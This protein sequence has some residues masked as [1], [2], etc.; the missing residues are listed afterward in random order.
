M[1]EPGRDDVQRSAAEPTATRDDDESI[2]W[3]LAAQPGRLNTDPR[4]T[5]FETLLR[6]F[7]RGHLLDL[8]CGHG[9]FSALAEGLGWSVT[10]VDVRTERRPEGHPGI[11]W[12]ES[13]VR[14][15]EVGDEPDVIAV[16][17]LLYHLE[18]EAQRDL[19]KRCAHR[20]T[21]ID[22]HHALT[23]VLREGGYEGR[24]F[25]EDVT[26]PTASWGNTASFWPTEDSFV[27]M[28]FDAGYGTVLRSVPAYLPD[29]TFWLCLPPDVDPERHASW[30]SRALEVIA[31]EHAERTRKLD[32]LERQLEDVHAVRM[33]LEAELQKRTDALA[34][35]R[36]E[37][38]GLRRSYDRL[39]GHP[40]VRTLRRLGGALPGSTRRSRDA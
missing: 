6:Q 3:Y 20:P 12:V 37:I 30:R 7:P 36:A 5:I 29:R 25:S 32:E 8:A 27:R 34:R 21:I 40:A 16:L 22:T 18:L 2:P 23:P 28:L 24:L 11:R 35:A 33:R 9:R 17:G 19:L 39:A 13:D 31:T 26:R 14:D 10:A 4:L 1:S 38:D 15:Y